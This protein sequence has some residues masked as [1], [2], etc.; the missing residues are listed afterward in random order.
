MIVDDDERV[1]QGLVRTFARNDLDVSIVTRASAAT[2]WGDAPP[3]EIAIVDL[4][5]AD[6]DGIEVVRAIKQAAPA[7]RCV[8]LSGY[9]TIDIAV[10]A[11]HAGA[12]QV[13]AKP[14]SGRDVLA[15]LAGHTP[16]ATPTLHDVEVAHIARVLAD[17]NHNISEAARRLGIYRSSLQR[18]LRKLDLAR[19]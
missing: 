1:A 5:L 8:L 14:I 18:K 17:C 16:A 12:E 4:R 9:V 10:R 11:A 13:L 15:R 3:P 7:T 19:A 6:G 2:A